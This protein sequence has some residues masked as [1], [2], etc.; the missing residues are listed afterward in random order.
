MHAAGCFFLT[1]ARKTLYFED[2]LSCARRVLQLRPVLSAPPHQSPMLYQNVDGRRDAATYLQT[3]RPLPSLQ[4]R[5]PRGI[6]LKSPVC[7]EGVFFF[8]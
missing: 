8:F 7:L 1:R 3:R 5:A 6:A 4:P 2:A